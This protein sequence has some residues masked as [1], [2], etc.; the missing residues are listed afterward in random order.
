MATKSYLD[1]RGRADYGLIR[2]DARHVPELETYAAVYYYNA[3][4]DVFIIDS[5]VGGVTRH[6]SSDDLI[7]LNDDLIAH[8]NRRG[9]QSG[10]RGAQSR[11]NVKNAIKYKA[12]AKSVKNTALERRNSLLDK[13]FQG[14]YDMSTQLLA[15]KFMEQR[16][17]LSE[18]LQTTGQRR[19]STFANTFEKQLTGEN[20]A[21]TGLLSDVLG[22]QIDIEEA[23]KERTLKS[24]ISQR[25][26]D[27]A[28]Y[29]ADIT[30]Y[31]YD[32]EGKAGESA[33]NAEM[34]ATII[35][36]IAKTQGG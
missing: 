7:A 9:H 36:L 5:K 10:N 35:S 19:S 18:A 21:F 24:I 28:K 6:Y 30:K 13:K 22:K 26:A 20:L 34:I 17:A 29:G 12:I 32:Q 16:G 2:P 8:Y 25:S 15:P 4:Y 14:I 11:K 23:D 1:Y 33:G 27:A 31:G 3:E